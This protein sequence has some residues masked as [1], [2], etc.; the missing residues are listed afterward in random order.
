M[1][2]L[3]VDDDAA[4]REYVRDVLE[5]AGYSVREA[6][7][8]R[9]ALQ[10]V[11]KAMPACIVLDLVMPGLSGF[12]TLRA[13]RKEHKDLAPVVVLTSMEGGG[14]RTYATRVNK[15]DAFVTKGQLDDRQTGL[16][17]QVRRLTADL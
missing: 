5:K 14:T 7:D 12:D 15:A 4:A 10:A 8:G 3:V 2:V 16:L 6:A 9:T 11:Q 1:T 13:L 17:S